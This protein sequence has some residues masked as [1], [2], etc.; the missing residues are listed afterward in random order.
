MTIVPPSDLGF[1]SCIDLEV[2]A[3]ISR[4]IVCTEALVIRR[5][6]HEPVRVVRGPE[7]LQIYTYDPDV[8]ATALMIIPCFSSP[9]G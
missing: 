9:P 5:G 3:A 8:G 1:T 7:W 4:G 6:V 2:C